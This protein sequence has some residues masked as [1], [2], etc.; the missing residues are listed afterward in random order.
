[1]VSLSNDGRV[2]SRGSIAD[3]LLKDKKLL[4]EVEKAKAENAAEE[5]IIDHKLDEVDAAPPAEMTSGRNTDGKLI[6][7]EEIEEGHVSW[8]ARASG[9]FRASCDSLTS[10]QLVFIRTN[11][12]VSALEL[13][14]C[15]A[16]W[17]LGM[18]SPLVL[19]SL[20]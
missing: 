15:L 11:L 5:Q 3:V 12:V 2:V 1:M 19:F 20:E 16:S 18:C 17:V 4:A 8:S 14:L 7:P 9:G 6:I 13:C 10:L